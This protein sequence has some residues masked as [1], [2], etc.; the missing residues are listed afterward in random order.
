MAA[1]GRTR[2]SRRKIGRIDCQNSELLSATSKCAAYDHR[3]SRTQTSV[4]NQPDT[5]RIE[6]IEFH[7][8]MISI[9]RFPSIDE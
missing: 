6:L 9:V 2:F 3:T 1:G 5:E 8:S 4:T 7:H